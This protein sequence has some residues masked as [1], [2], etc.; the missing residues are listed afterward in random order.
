MISIFC[1]TCGIV[2]LSD[3]IGYDYYAKCQVAITIER[4]SY[5]P[6]PA[7]AVATDGQLHLIQPFLLT[8]PLSLD[9]EANES[10]NNAAIYDDKC[11]ESRYEAIQD[12]SKTSHVDENSKANTLFDFR[13][14][15]VESS[16]KKNSFRNLKRHN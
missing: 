13:S 9:N 4:G 11:E 3:D 6:Y 16:F 12:M 15:Q 2:L 7:D 14:E 8:H 5:L 1:K 10:N